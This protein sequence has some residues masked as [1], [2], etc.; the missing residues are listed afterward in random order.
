MKSILLSIHPK[1][2]EKI[3]SGEKTIEVRKTVPKM[4]P[5][6]V[7][8][9]ETRA[10]PHGKGKVIGEFICYRVCKF[11][12]YINT[13]GTVTGYVHHMPAILGEDC[14]TWEEFHGYMKGKSGYDWIISSLKIYNKPRELSEFGLTRAPQSWQ[15]LKENNN[16]L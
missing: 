16:D 2:A 1:W 3:A 10:K 9:Y 12:P 13:C 15:Y 8:I 5:F 14:L 4:C 7:Y 6:K 11:E